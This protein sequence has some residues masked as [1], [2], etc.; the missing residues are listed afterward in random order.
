MQNN[1]QLYGLVSVRLSFIVKQ[2]NFLHSKAG[3][4]ILNYFLAAHELPTTITYSTNIPSKAC[5]YGFISIRISPFVRQS[6]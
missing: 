5:V 6:D 4:L 1:A 3:I 2:L